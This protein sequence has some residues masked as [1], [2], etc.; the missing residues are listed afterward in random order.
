M[1][2]NFY[3]DLPL[4]F[5][6]H[7]VSGDV[8]PIVDEL[9]IKRSITNLIK[10]PK[11]SKPFRPEYGST[12]FNYL[13]ENQDMFTRHNIKESVYET[14]SMFEPRVDVINVEPTFDDNGVSLKITY[15]IKNTNTISNLTTTVKR[16][17]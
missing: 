10:T 3:K 11:G 6:P 5:T 7:P 14:I 1:A 12:I 2:T 8:R 9:A 15:K 17:A 13:F 4:D 16:V